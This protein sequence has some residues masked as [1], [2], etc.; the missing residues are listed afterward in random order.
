M[1][2]GDIQLLAIALG[3]VIFLVA[4]IV[5]KARLHP[6][7]ALI[8]ASVAVGFLAGMPGDKLVKSIED[9]AGRTL[10]A[11]GLVVAL[12]A[13]LGKILADT[14]VTDGIANTIL[15]RTSTRMLP[16]VMTVVAFVI[17]IPMFFEVGLVVLLPL[18]FS[19]ARK[20]DE[21]SALRGS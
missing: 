16:W 4:L 1:T 2:S 3:G 6:L 19:V 12:G 7:L 11:V 13:M 5:S 18:I 9:G 21:T 8:I 17:G 20:L 14:G 15:N 10:G